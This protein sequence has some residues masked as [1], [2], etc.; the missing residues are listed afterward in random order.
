[1]IGS[2][3]NSFV[4]FNN[5]NVNCDGESRDLALP[6][7]E[8]FGIKYQIKV[9]DELLPADTVLYAA[10]CNQAC[11]T[12]YDDDI[13][14]APTCG[15]FV[16]IDN[17]GDQLLD[18]YFPLLVGNYAPQP[19]QPQI[20]EGN[21]TK[22][23]FLQVI[24]DLYEFGIPGTDFYY[25]CEVPV[26]SDIVVFYN[27]VGLAQGI[28]LTEFYGYGYVNF[29]NVDMD[30][31]VEMDECFRYCILNAEK[32]NLACSNLFYRVDERFACNYTTVFNYYNEENGFDFRYVVY[33]D[34]VDDVITEN[35]IRLAVRFDKPTFQ[36]EENVFRRSDKVQQRLS[37]LIGKEWLG[38]TSYLSDDQH[39]KV[40]VM[41]KHDVLHVQHERR[42]INRRMTQ[43]GD[44]DPQ[45]PDE[46]NYISSP[47]EFR[48][49]DWQQSYTNNNCGFNC[50]VEVVSDCEGGGGGVVPPCP[51]KFSDQFQVPE[52]GTQPTYQNDSLIG[53]NNASVEVYREGVLQYYVSSDYALAGGTGTITFNPALGSLERVAIVEI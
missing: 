38:Q 27:G 37:T 10:V 40:V 47:A 16:F 12:I 17:N 51:D 13:E 49:N 6:V 43:I 30:G 23:E 33:N 36:V 28:T 15:R 21:Y 3:Q 53:L 18:S 46:A 19:G 5:L 2:P 52:G 29:P 34:G 42:N 9:E 25:C 31:I 39:G 50:G 4:D 24:A 14:V 26:I 11:E 1:M 44:Y 32:D 35:Q 48:I 8:G 45:Y 41:L 7:Y 20:P 22:Q